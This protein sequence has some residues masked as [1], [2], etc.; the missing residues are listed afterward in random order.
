[1]KNKWQSYVESYVAFLMIRQRMEPLVD[2][3]GLLKQTIFG[4]ILMIVV[5]G[6]IAFLFGIEENFVYVVFT[7][8]TVVFGSFL[9]YR[10]GQ[11]KRIQKMSKEKYIPSRVLF[12]DGVRLAAFLMTAN[13]VVLYTILDAF[14]PWEI[15]LVFAVMALALTIYSRNVTENAFS[16]K[17]AILLG[18]RWFWSL[19]FLI[20]VLFSVVLNSGIP[21]PYL[22]YP[23]AWLV[24]G[25]LYLLKPYLSIKI[26]RQKESFGVLASLLI[27]FAACI[28]FSRSVTNSLRPVEE[29]NA[30]L[31]RWNPNYTSVISL[32]QQRLSGI[33]E[34]DGQQCITTRDAILIL[35]EQNHVE[36]VVDA[37]EGTLGYIADATDLYVVV[38]DA[39]LAISSTTDRELQYLATIYRLE[40]DGSTEQVVSG[41]LLTVNQYQ[42]Q[43]RWYPAYMLV[44]DGDIVSAYEANEI[45]LTLSIM[46]NRTDWIAGEEFPFETESILPSLSDEITVLSQNDEMFLFT[47]D[48]RI[49]LYTCFQYQTYRPMYHRGWFA[50]QEI[51]GSKD[52]VV[53]KLVNG[54]FVEDHRITGLQDEVLKYGNINGTEVLVFEDYTLVYIEGDSPQTINATSKNVLISKD[55]V[56][57]YDATENTVSFVDLEDPS[58]YE[59]TGSIYPF[60]PILSLLV[61]VSFLMSGETFSR[62]QREVKS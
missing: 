23:L 22:S 7:T 42:Y 43:Q 36:N 62:F 30:E 56:T 27:V 40:K 61:I 15:D 39:S 31:F 13:V 52:L 51:S 9:L 8:N 17:Q 21:S 14:F 32:D 16:L 49:D 25:L 29:Q 6:A 28:S 46:V 10:T 45:S 60:P 20:I 47:V 50:H 1:M 55:T 3:R 54:A 38:T 5:F 19:V 12:E 33:Y 57:V 11:E 37:P 41:S 24:A 2:K 44:L 48:G 59:M 35:D 53:S 34:W 4:T 18:E 58:T 26:P